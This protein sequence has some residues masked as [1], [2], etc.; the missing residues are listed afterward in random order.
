MNDWVQFIS[1]LS[2][3]HRLKLR[4]GAPDDL[5]SAFEQK[6][7]SLPEE[8]RNLLK[9]IN[10]LSLEWFRILPIKDIRDLKETWDDLE[11]ANDPK[12]SKFL[13][14]SPDL[15]NRF[16]IFAEIGGSK[17]AAFERTDDTI[18]YEGADEM[19]QTDLKLRG[20]LEISMKEVQEL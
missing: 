16:L 15:L 5:I 1:D 12:A 2:Q 4:N 17:C 13:S 11:R 20:F 18:W 10:G 8:L 9:V 6:H 7:G 19:V 14:R 3:A